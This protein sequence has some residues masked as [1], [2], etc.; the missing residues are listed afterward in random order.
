MNLNCLLIQGINDD[1]SEE[2]FSC[3]YTRFDIQLERMKLQAAINHESQLRQQKELFGNLERKITELTTKMDGIQDKLFDFI[4]AE[5]NAQVRAVTP[6]VD[7]KILIMNGIKEKLQQHEQILYKMIDNQNATRQLIKEIDL[8][9]HTQILKN[10]ISNSL[11]S[12]QKIDNKLKTIEGNTIPKIEQLKFYEDIQQ[13]LSKNC[14]K[15]LFN[16]NNF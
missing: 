6:A 8:E 5:T 7:D 16:F 14:L 9:D 13:Q 4:K 11:V 3:D 2:I 12:L 15:I 10:T 1:I